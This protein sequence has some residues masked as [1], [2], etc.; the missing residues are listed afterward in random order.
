MTRDIKSIF[1]I[2]SRHA[3]LFLISRKIFILISTKMKQYSR[4]AKLIVN[5][6]AVI[7]TS[8]KLKPLFGGA[9][10]ELIEPYTL[11]VI[12]ISVISNPILPGT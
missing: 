11:N 7:H 3:G 12:K 9:R 10:V 2:F 6:I 4:M 8:I 1:V 5:M